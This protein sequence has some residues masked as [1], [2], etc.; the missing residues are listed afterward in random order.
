[1]SD[2][3]APTP[4]N[5]DNTEFLKRIQQYVQDAEA[6][7]ALADGTIS[8]AMND[9]DF[10]FVVKMCAVLE[11]LLK[12]AVREHV[13]RKMEGLLGF[14]TKSDTLIKEIGELGN[15]TLRKILVEIGA[16]DG[17]L[18]NFLYA[19]F[20]VRHRYAHHIANAHLSVL[21][22][23]D[24]IADEGGDPK[25]LDKLVALEKP[26]SRGEL[27]PMA[28]RA[29]MFFNIASVLQA[30]VH[31]VKPPPPLPTGGLLGGTLFE[32]PLPL[33][34]AGSTPY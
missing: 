13:R 34:D 7:M 28:L 11:P 31:M 15:D 4:D 23:C 2:T 24:K 30:A 29:V 16:I 25:L 5:I 32:T 8:S 22:V 18:S 19:L 3:P 17:G 26:I 14:T 27:K 6:H 20:L 21:E 9:S 1:M 33:R 10:L 12:E